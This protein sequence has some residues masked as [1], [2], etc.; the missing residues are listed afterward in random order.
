ME[1]LGRLALLPAAPA[2][3]WELGLH[4]AAAAAPRAA[5]NFGSLLAAALPSVQ[6][7]DRQAQA[8]FT[9]DSTPAPQESA[10]KIKTTA[11]DFEALLVYQLLKQMWATLPESNLFG[12]STAGQYFREMWLDEVAKKIAGGQGLGIAPIIERELSAAAQRSS[13]PDAAS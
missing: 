11:Q 12:N 4:A 6:P 9:A 8:I 2:S 13:I 10:H 1:Q 7:A 5:A 3:G